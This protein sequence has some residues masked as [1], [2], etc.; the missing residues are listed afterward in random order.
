MYFG[1]GFEMLQV[2]EDNFCPLSISNLFTTLL[3]LFNNTQGNKKGIDVLLSWFAG[4]L[5]ALSRLAVAIPPILQAMLFLW[6]MHS[7]YADLLSQFAT[8][9]KD[10]LVATIDSVVADA[11]YMD[12]FVVVGSKTKPIVLTS[13]PRSP[14]AALVTTDKKGKEFWTTFEWLATYDSGFVASWFTPL[15]QR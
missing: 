11:W 5:G 4:H 3:A 13:S 10:L 7:C 12:D 9:H 15:P 1:K 14:A 2:L 6:A 8:K